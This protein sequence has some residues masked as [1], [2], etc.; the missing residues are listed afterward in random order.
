MQIILLNNFNKLG[1]MGKQI[2]VKPGYARN[3]LIPTGSAIP[4]TK[5]NI[6]EIQKKVSEI[7]ENLKLDIKESIEKAKKIN[8]IKQIIIFAKIGKNN[9]LFGSVGRKHISKEI[10]KVT[11][12][13]VKKNEVRL[14]NRSLRIAGKHIINFKFKNQICAKLIIDIQQHVL[15]K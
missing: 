15:K 14:K 4:A 6:Q 8:S 2:K 11:G 10:T 3:F 1:K 12:F 5:K 9:K 7:N 13:L